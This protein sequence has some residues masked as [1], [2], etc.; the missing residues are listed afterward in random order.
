LSFFVCA[1]NP[2]VPATTSTF[3]TFGVVV[4]VTVVNAASSDGGERVTI[5][6]AS[7]ERAHTARAIE[8][9]IACARMTHGARH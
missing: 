2:R 1:A 6:P 4:V 8:R 3:I 9:R 5:P 7:R